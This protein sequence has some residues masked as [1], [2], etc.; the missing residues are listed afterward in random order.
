MNRR[1]EFEAL[2]N[3]RHNLYRLARLHGLEDEE[4]A[5]Q[6]YGCLWE[7]NNIP[8]DIAERRVPPNLEELGNPDGFIVLSSEVVWLHL[9]TFFKTSGCQTVFDIA[10]DY[11]RNLV[12]TYDFLT[13]TFMFRDKAN[14]Y[15]GN[16]QRFFVVRQVDNRAV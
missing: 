16:P 9:S 1:E 6:P 4:Q 3:Y 13:E 12:L 15:S 2:L 14:L 7:L 8:S 10:P 11:E 5:D